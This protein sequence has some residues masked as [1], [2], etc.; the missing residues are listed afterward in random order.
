MIFLVAK[1]PE[2][3][4]SYGELAVLIGG[5]DSCLHKICEVMDSDDLLEVNRYI[6]LQPFHLKCRRVVQW[7]NR[8]SAYAYD[9]EETLTLLEKSLLSA[10]SGNKRVKY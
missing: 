9:L 6:F 3:D 2:V 4:D 8:T 5:C 1:L 10:H 7:N